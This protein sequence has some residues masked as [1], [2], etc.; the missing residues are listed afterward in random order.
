MA[1]RA[2]FQFWTGSA[3]VTAVNQG[4][5]AVISMEITDTLNNPKRLEV[6]LNDAAANP[7]S[8][9]ASEQVGP[10]GPD[11]T[12][13]LSEFQKVRVLAPDTG[14]ILFYGKIYRL[15]EEYHPHRGQLL[16][17]TAY[18][19]LKELV[20]MPTD[21]KE[22][23]FVLKNR[24]RHQVIKDI[25]HST[26]EASLRISADNVKITGI[27]NPS[28][29]GSDLLEASEKTAANIEGEGNVH[30]NTGSKKALSAILSLASSDPHS[31]AAQE[32]DF[33]WDFYVSDAFN[34]AT[35]S[36]N[37]APTQNFNYY[38]RGSRPATLES[39]SAN[40]KGLHLEYP[41]SF[42]GFTETGTHKTMLPEYAFERDGEEI[43]TEGLVN[44]SEK[45]RSAD[46]NDN[47]IQDTRKHI[48]CEV[49]DVTSISG[50][51]QW[52]GKAFS[53]AERVDLAST[54]VAETLRVNI[55][56]ILYPVGR[57]Q[58]QDKSSG[59]GTV[60]VSYEVG[61]NTNVN[62]DTYITGSS[63]IT[64]TGQQ[65]GETF[66]ITPSTGRLSNKQTL[67]RAYRL[68]RNP[69]SGADGLRRKLFNALTKSKEVGIRGNIRMLGI[70]VTYYDTYATNSTATTVTLSGDAFAYGFKLGMTI[71]QID[72]AG[73]VQAY[74]WASAI[75]NSSVITATLNSGDWDGYT[76]VSNKI[77]VYI[78][79]R[80]GSYIYATNQLQHIASYQF[81]NEVMYSEGE[82]I[83]ATN[84]K[85]QATQAAAPHG[86]KGLGVK[87]NAISSKISEENAPIGADTDT[88][89]K[90]ALPWTLIP[91]NTNLEAIQP[92]GANQI[93][94]NAGVL[95]LG[96]GAYTYSIAQAN[97]ATF[98]TAH[99]VIYFDPDTST[100]ALQITPKASY[101]NNTEHIL[102]GW[103]KGVSGGTAIVYTGTGAVGNTIAVD[104]TIANGSIDT[105]HIAN[106][107]ITSALMQPSAQPWISTI[108]WEKGSTNSHRRV[109]WSDGASGNPVVRFQSGDEVTITADE[110][111]ADLAL[112]TTHYMYIG[113]ISGT[114]TIQID[115]DYT[116]A[117][118]N[119][120]VLL[121][122]V[123][124]GGEDGSGDSTSGDSPTILPFNAK[125]PTISAIS[126]AADAISTQALQAGSITATRIAA[127]TITANEIASNAITTNELLIGSASNAIG[128]LVA[129]G[130]LDLGSIGSGNL[131]NISEGSTKRTV[132]ANEKTGAGRAYGGL[133]TSNR[134][135]QPIGTGDGAKFFSYGQTSGTAVVIDN[136][137]IKGASGLGGS[138]PNFTGGTTQFSLSSV[139]GK[140]SAGAGKIV[141]DANGV[142]ILAV[143]SS[144]SSASAIQ[145][146]YG[147]SL[148][149]AESQSTYIGMRLSQVDSGGTNEF[150]NLDW[151]QTVSDTT[152][153]SFNLMRLLEV[154][155]ITGAT[156][157]T[158]IWRPPL[159][160]GSTGEYLKISGGSGT[161]DSPY[162]T[163]WDTPSGGGS[164]TH[165]ST[166]DVTVDDLLLN[167]SI[168]DNSSSY[169]KITM[170]TSYMDF[171]VKR[172]GVNA[173]K[174]VLDLDA[175]ETPARGALGISGNTS[176]SYSLK[177][178][179][180]DRA[181]QTYASS[182]W[183][184]AS[185]ERLKTDT[186]T[187][188]GATAKIKAL[189]PIT[190]KWSAAYQAATGLPDD[191][192]IGYLASEY[193]TV[194]P[195]DITT[196]A[197]DL[198]QLSD[199]S[200]ETG[201]YSP[202][203][204]SA[205]EALPDGATMLVENIKTINPDSVV[206][207][208]VA[209][210]K[211]LEARI[212][213]LEAG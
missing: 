11:Q 159:S 129:N 6:R 128:G 9:T 196:T 36:G 21:D 114:Q 32:N 148:S 71:A 111:D 24:Q 207:Y 40:Y 212:A 106:D 61:A 149:N 102:I 12:N 186:A 79:I 136:L 142:Q 115:T 175:Y 211:E 37:H 131:D 178:S 127:N 34:L 77:R 44:T 119:T 43:Y 93:T 193:A 17:V 78:P 33:G 94:V 172:D 108:K 180:P 13:E 151:H 89:A 150:T 14:V 155:G 67:R 28:H 91:T 49:W 83:M 95:S 105:Q 113:G 116:N 65:T 202:K 16:K 146:K 200:Y 213:A 147:S 104:T 181:Y 164:H 4:Y 184:N 203:V 123:T 48:R 26:N 60:L 134:V 192:H 191:T 103:C 25:I 185:D 39:N 122:T 153:M 121:A 209:A 170:N 69:Q 165:G 132:T 198:I 41:T 173:L 141:L 194:F 1:T 46:A 35:S 31:D 157:Q 72:D 76:G 99:N 130:D 139:D 58:W 7:F 101:T 138:F 208:L 51:F 187:L 38:K 137:G 62:M 42:G 205:K 163:E 63:A 161:I 110:S 100:T 54:D 10:F 160:T 90:A 23:P 80:A 154:G 22:A 156:N 201:E 145:F 124:V 171:Y 15:S 179:S 68:T 158:G 20:D 88:F 118:G 195:N 52:K 64:V 189:N 75:N 182:Y 82:A 120:R 19:N 47:T 3:W 190:Y 166:L 143:T 199:D 183:A 74:G 197:T 57:I 176:S 97:S 167:G 206:P 29:Q 84:F 98:S 81:V 2:D 92:Y 152:A 126:I 96:G 56:N 125:E 45:T 204:D 87:P 85:T 174:Q 5:N 70:P 168:I 50:D 66:V 107:A 188:L 169:C 18:D 144:L 210:I 8:D 86:V 109:K 30:I 162:S 112:N 55:S 140:A 53:E 133:N 27:T 117:V 73:D 177:I 59:S 135:S